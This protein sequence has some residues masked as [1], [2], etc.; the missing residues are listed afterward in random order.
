MPKIIKDR[1]IVDDHWLVIHDSSELPAQGD[2]IVTLAFWHAHRDTL[3]SRAGKLGV[4]VKPDDD[5]AE[6]A[7]DLTHFA[8][9]AIDFPAFADGRGFSSA[10]LLRTRYGYSGELRAVGDVL[11]DQM[12]YMQRVGFNA[13]AVR[14]DRS[15][16]D[17]LKSLNDFTDVYQGSADQSQP[18]F[19]RHAA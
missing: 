10:Y 14:A 2:V 16:E 13:F 12:F 8:L 17:A 6:I 3:L 4:W 9:I 19:R 7:N 15:I 11:R 5:V 18:H 1:A